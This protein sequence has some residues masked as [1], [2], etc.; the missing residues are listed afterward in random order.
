MNRQLSKINLPI[1]AKP[2]FEAS[3][4]DS[5]RKQDNDIISQ[6]NSQVQ[7]VGAILP[8]GPAVTPTNAIHHVS[9]SA[10]VATI[11]P[12]AGFTGDLTLI[13]DAGFTTEFRQ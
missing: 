13:A 12:S 9:G 8:S 3:L 5:L 6:I 7:G 4:L 11:V 1:N 2:G 10:P